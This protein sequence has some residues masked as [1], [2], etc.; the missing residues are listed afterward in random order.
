MAIP[1]LQRY[2]DHKP[3]GEL[4]AG[5]AIGPPAFSKRSS[6][7][8]AFKRSPSSLVSGMPF[9]MQA[10]ADLPVPDM[11][12][13]P[14]LLACPNP[15]CQATN[16]GDHQVCQRC[17]TPLLHRYLWM[18]GEEAEA[19]LPGELIADRYWSL[20]DRIVLDTR[21]AA[22]PQHQQD[23]TTVMLPYLRLFRHRTQ[24]PQVHDLVQWGSRS[25]LLL[26]DAPI[27]P[28]GLPAAAEVQAGTLL[29]TLQSQWPYA[30]PQRQL[31]WL[32]QMVQLCGPLRQEGVAS[33]LLR[34]DLLRVDGSTLRLLELERSPLGFDLSQLGQ[35]WLTWVGTAHRSIA[36][37]LGILAEKLCNNVAT[38]E[39]LEELLAGALAIA[40]KA[41]SYEMRLAT[42]SD[43]GVQRQNNE[44]ACWPQT[45]TFRLMQAGANSSPATYQQSL[46][47]VCDGLGG[48]EGGEVASAMALETLS[49]SLWEAGAS[50][51]TGPL[52]TL[53][54][55]ICEANDRIFER[56]N[57]ERRQRR[58]RMATT[59]V[60]TQLLEHL[61]YVGHVGDSRIYR[62][63]PQ[64]CRQMTVDDDIASSQVLLGEELYRQAIR[65][66][67]SGALT[68][69]LGMAESS[70]LSPTVQR[71]FCDDDTVLLLC[72]DGLSDY[73][74]L[75]CLWPQLL[76]ALFWEGSSV[77]TVAAKLL[78]A[79]KEFNGHDNITIAVVYLR[80]LDQQAPDSAALTQLVKNWAPIQLQNFRM[81]EPI[82]S[83][84]TQT[85]DPD[86][87]QQRR[88]ILGQPWILALAAIGL[89]GILVTVGVKSQGLGPQNAPIESR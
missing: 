75:E 14:P 44:D 87:S 20:G 71:F 80:I 15:R 41:Q 36:P 77:A 73:D 84:P 3:A 67:S 70:A 17:Q 54:K 47:M 25:L 74:R 1:I 64:S 86:L 51:Q 60:L 8:Q 45:G 13:A 81:L 79:A 57:Q 68:Q 10:T 4:V 37:F 55:A 50:F 26:E 23:V 82:V 34:G 16:S 53:E 35:I 43:P 63:T 65:Q 89:L 49:G 39:P 2:L 59:V 58:Q 76:P 5:P 42:C 7:H 11:A 27:Y 56:N 18:V 83:M 38:L 32:W 78:K 9:R 22:V 30:S 28:Q 72:S 52:P 48:H 24:V 21:P 6:V 40:G 31:N 85:T 61:L 46:V 29:P 88:K 19:I 12:S 62:L 66:P 33:T 69:A